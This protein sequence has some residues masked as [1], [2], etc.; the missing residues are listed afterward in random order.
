MKTIL[1]FISLILTAASVFGQSIELEVITGHGDI[2]QAANGSDLHFTLGEVMVQRY[3]NGEILTQGFHQTYEEATP[4]FET[5]KRNIEIK[6]YPN[7]ATDWVAVETDS[8]EKLYL[9]LFNTN[10][11]LLY[12]AEM[13]NQTETLD[14]SNLPGG[15]YYLNVA[16]KEGLIQSFKLQKVR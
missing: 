15:M 4:V 8:N 12:N 1:L 6:A 9:Q 13:T 5:P 11:Q 3:D 7:P 2:Y 14:V 16:D 10:G